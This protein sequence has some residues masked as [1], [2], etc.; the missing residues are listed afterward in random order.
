MCLWLTFC[1]LVLDALHL[2]LWGRGEYL[3]KG[4]SITLCVQ[5]HIRLEILLI[6]FMPLSTHSSNLLPPGLR[7]GRTLLHT[8]RLSRLSKTQAQGPISTKSM[9]FTSSCSDTVFCVLFSDRYGGFGVISEALLV[10][11]TNKL[12]GFAQNELEIHSR[13]QK[14]V[15]KNT[16]LGWFCVLGRSIEYIWHFCCV[17]GGYIG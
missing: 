2:Q 17:S 3:F 12:L 13:T 15:K 7:Q 4:V 16:I 11:T 9:S 5:L 10:Q 6:V 1:I 14:R 8:V